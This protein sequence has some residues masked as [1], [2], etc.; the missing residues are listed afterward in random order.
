M[1]STSDDLLFDRSKVNHIMLLEDDAWLFPVAD[2]S[3]TGDGYLEM[4][5]IPVVAGEAFHSEEEAAADEVM[6]SRSC[7]ERLCLLA[8]WPEGVIGKSIRVTGHGRTAFTV[9]GV[10]GEIRPG[11]IGGQ[12]LTSSIMFHDSQASTNVLIRFHQQTSEGMQQVSALLAYLLPT[13]ESTVLSYANE[14]AGRYN[15]SRNFRDA[16]VVG[17]LVAL[18]ICLIGLSGYIHHEMNRRRKETAI[19]KV[20]GA[21]LVDILLMYVGDIN[22]LALPALLVGGSCAALVA[23]R[24]LAQFAEKPPLTPLLFVGSGLLVL[25]IVLGVVTLNCYRAANENPALSI[26]SD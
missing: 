7:A 16:V 24:W 26:K 4:M 5:E 25:L 19:R 20:N 1:A 23:V 2:L 17:S 14:M 10:Y 6:L 11:I 8:N 15:E 9:C 22:R 13:R 12:E 18:A 21:T 3:A